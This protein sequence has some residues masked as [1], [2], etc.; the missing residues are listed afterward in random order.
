MKIVRCLLVV[1]LLITVAGTPAQA[2]G[3]FY[4]LNSSGTVTVNGNKVGSLPGEFNPDTPGIDAEQAW[5][6]LAVVD[7]NQ[8]AIRGDGRLVLNDTRIWQLPFDFVPAWYWT[9]LK[10]VGTTT[11]ALREDGQLAV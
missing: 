7:G 5:R 4:A 2:G 10:V 1:L 9:E 3:Y 6:D 8:Y 11:Y